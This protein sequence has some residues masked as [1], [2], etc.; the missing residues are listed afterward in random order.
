VP[1]NPTKT[2]ELAAF[3]AT[4]PRLHHLHFLIAPHRAFLPPTALLLPQ[5]PSPARLAPSILCSCNTPQSRPLPTRRPRRAPSICPHASAPRA[6]WTRTSLPKTPAHCRSCATC[7]SLP[8]WPSTSTSSAMLSESTRTWTLRYVR[9]APAALLTRRVSLGPALMDRVL[10]WMQELESECL[11]QNP[12][13]KLAQIGLALLK[14]VS[15]HKGL[16]YATN[17]T[18]LRPR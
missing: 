6:K 10:T 12:S 9:R 2:S 15:S 11:K 13:E 16:T 18:L 7:G 3:L 14:H 1:L 4:R 8:I 17:S 5:T